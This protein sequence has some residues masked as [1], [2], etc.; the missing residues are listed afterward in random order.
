[1][2][3]ILGPVPLAIM[4]KT[5]KYL[6]CMAAFELRIS[7][8]WCIN[9]ALLTSASAEMILALDSLSVLEVIDRSLC[10]SLVIDMSLMNICSTYT[11]II[12]MN[13]SYTPFVDFPVDEL[14]DS[15]CNFLPFFQQILQSILPTNSPQSSIGDLSHSKHDILDSVM[16]NFGIDDAIVHASIN[17]DCYVVF[18]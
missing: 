12:M 15:I 18:S 4:V 7:A 10:S 14:F 8:A 11:P 1:M 13:A 3:K 16:C 5:Y 17:A 2:N 6:I 9:F